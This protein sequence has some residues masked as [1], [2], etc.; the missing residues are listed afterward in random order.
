MP[1][2]L[3]YNPDEPMPQQQRD[4]TCAA[5]SLAWLNRA[6]GIMHATEE[7]AAVDYIG[8]PTHINAEWGL[9]DA[10][11]Q[12][13]VECLREQG[14]PAFNAWFGWRATYELATRM[15]LL[16]GGVGWNHWVGVRSGNNG[17]LQLANSA[18]GWRGIDQALEE[19]D[20][21]GL[22]PFAVLPVPLLTDFPSLPTT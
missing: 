16:I 19:A 11:G 7:F 10:S 21:Y 8:E 2:P 13:L 12:R 20:W 14:A 5:C 15:P 6:L 17:V 1:T 9:M 4:W 18:P 22:G 3:Y